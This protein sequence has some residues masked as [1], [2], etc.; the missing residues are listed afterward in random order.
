VLFCKGEEDK[1]EEEEEVGASVRERCI[2]ASLF[3]NRIFSCS[4]SCARIEMDAS[5]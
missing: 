4:R 1:E 2:D 3:F 5:L